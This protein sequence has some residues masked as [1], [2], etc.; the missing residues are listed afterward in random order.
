MAKNKK[1]AGNSNSD[2]I[3]RGFTKNI[4]QVQSLIDDLSVSMYGRTTEDES[5][6]LNDRF[7]DIMTNEIN[8]ITG[9]GSN[10]YNSFIG[11]LYSSSKSDMYTMKDINAKLDL[12]I[13]GNGANPAQYINDQYKNRMVQQADAEQISNQLI[14]LREAKS[15]MRD[16]IIST[17]L[18]TGR[19]NRVVT[20]E[21][22]TVNDISEHSIPIIEEMEK[23][24]NI[25]AR[26]KNIVD[27]TLGFGE[28]YVY[29]IPYH[30]VF[31]NFA[32][33]YKNG[34]RNGRN[35]FE[36]AGDSEVED[37]E[38]M[39]LSE[40]K[41]SDKSFMESAESYIS[42]EIGEE[43]SGKD[44]ENIAGDLKQILNTDRITI[45]T[46]PIPLPILEEGIESMK[47]FADV[48]INESGD[49]FTEA[50]GDKK[51]SK[52]RKIPGKKRGTNEGEK[53]Q[54]DED[55]FLRK[56]GEGEDGVYNQDGILKEEKMKPFEDMKDCYIKE[57]SPIQMIPVKIMGNVLF[58]I[59]IQTETAAPLSTILS[60]Q[61]QYRSK[62]PANRIDNLV[63]DISNRIVGKFNQ[64]FVSKNKEFKEI[65]ASALQ[66]YE[67]GNTKIHFQVVPK[68]YVT[69]FKINKDEDDNGHSMLE[70]SLFY[71]KLYLMLLMFKI[72]TIV[73]KSND[74]EINYIRTSGIDKNVY[75]KAQRIARQKQARRIT[76]NDMF[77]YTGVIN[78]IGAGNAIYMPMGKNNEKPIETE[79]LQGQS[80]ELNNDLMEMLRTNYILGTGVPSAIMNYLNEADFAKSIETANTKMNG[81]VINYQIDFNDPIT[82]LYQKLLG[83]T[84][85]MEKEAI[86][87][88]RVKFTEPKGASNVTT[89]DLI[90]N[91]SALQDFLVKV[92]FGDSP[93]D[94]IH[95]RKFISEV[96]RMHLPMINFDKIDEIY[97][98]TKV[99]ST[100]DKINNQDDLDDDPDYQ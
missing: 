81:R 78:K 9:N 1:D 98:S 7:N 89:Q 33:K 94:D 15:V 48:Y 76:I 55:A 60:Y 32:R 30:E 70:P 23:K 63:D 4:D 16:A 73:T 38:F 29:T 19:I 57:V 92:Y 85:N 80:V 28:Y 18:N 99:E 3:K 41:E 86:D 44:K 49:S 97:K 31:E 25:H 40:G 45:S 22:P 2:R 46:T 54:T 26:I 91:Y 53:L 8:G 12:D 95:V 62:D 100:G 87:S 61:S 11:Q 36:S 52:K 75:N 77:S 24:F 71:A 65:I 90:Q 74:Q 50:A 27:K 35:F 79:I 88:V 34:T 51:N 37:I 10:D 58:Y 42:K 69:A 83:Y 39:T 96:A 82:E 21:T 43:K 72:V 47:A 13:R 84:T 67:L 6:K 20:F 59:Y 64:D 68:E 66:Y 56:Y 93:T 14:E 5:D 17:D